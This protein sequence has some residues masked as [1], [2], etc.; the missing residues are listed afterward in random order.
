M[1]AP[2]VMASLAQSAPVLP[3][4]WCRKGMVGTVRNGLVVSLLRL[5]GPIYTAQLYLHVLVT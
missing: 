3:C 4:M 1:T 2:P 5:V